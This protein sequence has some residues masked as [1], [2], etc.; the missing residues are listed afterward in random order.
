MPLRKVVPYKVTVL[1]VLVASVSNLQVLLHEVS[2]NAVTSNIMFT[3]EVF[4]ANSIYYCCSII[5]FAQLPQASLFRI[6]IHIIVEIF[7]V[8]LVTLL[9]LIFLIFVG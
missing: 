4:I 2:S 1:F 5:T 9:A 8:I 7:F 3:E 6:R